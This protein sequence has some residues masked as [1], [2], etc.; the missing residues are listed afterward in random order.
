MNLIEERIAYTNGNTSTIHYYWGKDL[1]GS[2]QGAGGVG[3]LLYLTIDGST[4]VP[5]YDNNGNITHY[6]DSNG[7]VVAQYTYDAFGNTIAQSGLLANTFR[8]RYSTK[9]LDTET[10]LYYYGYRFYYPTLMRWLN[11]DPIKEDGGINLYAFCGNSS[12]YKIDIDGCKEWTEETAIQAVKGGIDWMRRQ[13]YNFAADALQYFLDNKTGN[14]DLSKYASEI[15]NNKNWQKSFINNV[16]GELSKKDPKGSNR[17]VEIGDIKHTSS[18]S[19][20]LSNA[21]F[22]QDFTKMFEHRFHPYESI[23]LFLAMYGSRYSYI[24]T[25]SWCVNKR[26]FFSKR[27]NININLNLKLICWDPLTY[28]YGFFRN[29]DKSYSAAQYLELNHKYKKNSIYLKWNENSSW[30]KKVESHSYYIHNEFIRK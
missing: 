22:F 9:Y 15:Y 23:S 11:R 8:H 19:K 10:S 29:L 2:F 30:I 17:K 20:D 4:F 16:I 26:H 3:G 12:L 13:G 27:Y 24:G 18:F 14:I 1:S 6:L 7:N 5:L 21:Q 28:P 25:A